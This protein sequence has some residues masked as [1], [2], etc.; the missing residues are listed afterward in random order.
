MSLQEVNVKSSESLALHGRDWMLSNL[1]AGASSLSREL[2]FANN[3][4]VDMPWMYEWEDWELAEWQAEQLYRQGSKDPSSKVCPNGPHALLAPTST[5][6]RDRVTKE[7]VVWIEGVNDEY[8]V[9]WLAERRQHSV[10]AMR[11]VAQSA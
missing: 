6:L 8:V 7:R 11:Y 5:A 2:V 4:V 10:R 1:R 9:N 3:D